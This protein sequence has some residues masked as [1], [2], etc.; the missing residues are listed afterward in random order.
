[1]GPAPKSRY[2]A[3]RFGVE[4]F[5]PVQGACRGLDHDCLTRLEIVDRKNPI[6]L[7]FE[8]FGKSAVQ[9]DAISAE[10]FAQQEVAPHAVKASSADGVAVGDNSLS[11]AEAR[12]VPPDLHNLAREFMA[13]NQRETRSEFPFVDVQISPAQAAS[14]DAHEDF[15]RASLRVVGISVRKAA[16]GVINNGFHGICGGLEYQW[17]VKACPNTTPAFRQ[18]ENPVDPET[19]RAI[20]AEQRRA[21]ASSQAGSQCPGGLPRDF[22]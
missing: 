18:R 12:H 2:F 10:V 16:R 22:A 1:M 17:C 13:R 11:G 21:H 20:T 3:P 15:V 6:R 19:V 4:D 9:R 8:I 7:H 5:N 14:V